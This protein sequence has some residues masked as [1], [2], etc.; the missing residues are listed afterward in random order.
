MVYRGNKCNYPYYRNGQT[1]GGRPECKK[2]ACH[3]YV[4]KSKDAGLILFARCHDHEAQV[5]E[6]Y[7]HRAE[8]DEETYLVASI[9]E[10]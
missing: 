5:H 1:R 8:V 2:T 10:S 7:L 4:D 6:P 9:M 3:F